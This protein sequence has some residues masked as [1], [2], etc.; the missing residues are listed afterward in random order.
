M[1]AGGVGE[2]IKG[3]GVRVAVRNLAVM[4][5]AGYLRDMAG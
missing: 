5:R 1:M 3:F 2:A 4:D